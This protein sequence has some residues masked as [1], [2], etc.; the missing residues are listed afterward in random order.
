MNSSKNPRVLIENFLAWLTAQKGASPATIE[1]YK[2]DLTSFVEKELARNPG[3]DIDAFD[4]KVARGYAAHLFRSGYSKNSVARKMATIRSFFRYLTRYGYVAQN[5]ASRLRNPKVDRP[6]AGFL[7][8]DEAFAILETMNGSVNGREEPSARRNLALTE[9]LYGSG[10]RISEA[11]NLDVKDYAP[12]S[13]VIRVTGKGDRERIAPLTAACVEALDAW[14]LARGKIA[15]PEEKALFV[16][17]RG[18][19]L[20]RREAGRIIKNA[21]VKAGCNNPVSPH[22]L[23]HSFA[24]HLLDAGADLRATQE[25]LG[26]KRLS[27]T[28]RYTHLSIEKIILAYDKAHPVSAEERRNGETDK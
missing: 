8:V 28:E 21:C 1:A 24:T 26:H 12:G 9:L 10:L 19:R 17:A 13:R 20:D 18:G 2:T 3:A 6:R 23:R 11:L 15:K 27:T 4:V 14:L 5:P 7:N 25:L 16:G 22:G